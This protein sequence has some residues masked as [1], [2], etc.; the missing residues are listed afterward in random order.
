MLLS[1]L[2]KL[3][4]DA[5][6]A[7]RKADLGIVV[8]QYIKADYVGHLSNEHRVSP[9]IN[10][11]AYELE[12]P[13]WVPSKGI[14]SKFTTSPD[15]S[16]PLRC[17]SQV[18]HQPL[19]SLG[20]F[21]AEQF[22]ERC[23]LE[24]LV[25]EGTLYLM[26]IDFEWPQLDRGLDPKRDFKLS[27]PADLNLEG[28]LEIRPYQI[29]TSTK[30]PKLQNLSDFD[31]EDQDVLSPRI[32]PLEPNRIASAVSDEAAYKKLSLEM[33]ALTGDRLV[34]R[35]D[36]IKESASRFNL[37]RT[38]TISVEDAIK[39]CHS[40]SSDFVKQGVK[41]DELI[42]LFHAFLPAR[43]SAWAYARP[44]NPVVIVDALWGLPDGLQVLP[45][46]TYE[47]NVAQKK[48]IGTKTTFKHAFLIEVE[49]GNWDYRNIKTRSGRKQVLTSADKIEIAI[50]TARIAD[51]LQEDAQ[52][53]WFC[54][55]PS[56]YQVGRNLPWFRSREVLD[57]SPR[58]EIKYKPYRVSNSTDLK[59]VPLER[60]TLQLSPEADLIRD[61]EFLE[62]VIEVAKAR[63]LPVQLEGS[64]LGH[65]YYRLNQENIPVILRNAPKYY[66]KRNAQVF[67]KIVRDK[68]PDSIAKG[69]ESVREAKLAKDDLQIGLAGKLLEE[70]D[71]FLRAKNKDESA[72]ELAD[73]LEVIK[74]LANCC[75]HS[76]SRIEQIAKEKETKRGGFNEG[77]VLIETALPHR[78]SPIEREQQVRIAD[79][80]RVESREN[81][82]EVPPSA[83]VS[84]SKGPGVIFS[85][86][87]DTTRYR[88]SI[89][90]GKLLLT[91]L[92]PKFEGTYEKQQELF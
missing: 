18:P 23:H 71:E 57:P 77:K 29:G 59:R 40:I 46:D 80:G 11:W 4:E 65:A 62:S 56:A 2:R 15:P 87:G 21:L 37:P 8:H 14:N 90:D 85:F 64:I 39:W 84:T 35:T 16:A 92:D 19:R 66:R 47:V 89:R 78:D 74:G 61:N 30:W 32:Y 54:G 69:G 22:S 58:Q 17:G 68:I 5:Q 52:I 45:V 6:T 33:K 9:T 70:L 51:K 81:S 10:Q 7:D 27:A 36:C 48:V 91:R 25:H 44:G 83:L 73:I 41:E 31:F 75:G 82:V 13:Q 38:D 3:Y 55:I 26:Q 53:M 12:L 42:F 88:V 79:L 28:A 76:W 72:A 67:G 50:R 43:A 63:S 86:Q 34:V 1:N 49:N 20:H 60:V 24:W